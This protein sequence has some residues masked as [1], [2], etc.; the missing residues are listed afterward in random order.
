V[1]P[2]P[3]S[4]GRRL[5]R[6]AGC[7][8]V[9][10]ALLLAGCGGRSPDVIV[11]LADTLR[12]DR[13]GPYGGPAGLTPFLDA[14]AASGTVFT[15]AYSTTSWTNPAI[16]SLFT[17]RYPSQHH[18]VR[19][20]SRLPADEVTLAE[21]LASE[22]YRRVGFLGNFRLMA[23]LG[24]AQGFDAW[25]PR[26]IRDKV[27]ARHLTQEAIRF[28]DQQLA[29][30]PWSRWT[31]RPLLLYLHL[32]DPHAPY[33]PPPAAR[34]AHVP[35]APA[36]VSG[37]EANAKLLAQRW[38]ELSD[39]EVAYLAA[40]YDAE[41]ASM[42]AQ[43]ARLFRRLGRR[44]LLDNA[45]VVVTAD[46]GEEFR[47]HGWLTH[48][49]AL[50]QESVRVPII[51]TGPGVPA[52][53]VVADDVS[54]VDI[55]PTLLELVGA[56]PEPRF[57][58]RSLVGLMR[59][60]A[61]SRDVL[62]ELEPLGTSV[63][64]RRHAAGLLRDGVALLTPPGPTGAAQAFD[65]RADPGETHPNPEAIA[66]EAASMSARLRQRR[67]ALATRAGSAETAPI[68]AEMRERLRALGYA[69]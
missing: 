12:A 69:N 6:G 17:S 37:A 30:R 28:Y 19:F 43:L 39:D 21:R 13:L 18:V 52:G 25:F 9:A 10:L 27:R 55:A 36:G 51:L 44:G 15:N 60:P 57:E 14:L 50:Y 2:A 63:E 32:M 45:I 7:A 64:M 54:I 8:A 66:Q 67:A 3:V 16:A 22:R 35:V 42:D 47:E 11:I 59:A 46:H 34:E 4:G 53:R 58:G 65:L 49:T 33:D 23:E 48:G 62:L 68:G 5:W 1:A 40:L 24:F 26:M 38:G 31:R 29:P 61:D 20:D 41:I 56:A